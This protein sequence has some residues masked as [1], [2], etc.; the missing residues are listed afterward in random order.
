MK[1]YNEYIY[2]YTTY[3]TDHDRLKDELFVNL[4]QQPKDV[5]EN[6]KQN[7]LDN[8]YNASQIAKI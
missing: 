7:P 2:E 6:I 8:K 1:L 5:T 3:D 4:N